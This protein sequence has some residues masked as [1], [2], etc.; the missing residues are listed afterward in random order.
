M[1]QFEMGDPMKKNVKSSDRKT[2]RAP[3]PGLKRPRHKADPEC[4][5]LTDQQI[6]LLPRI[7]ERLQG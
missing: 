7:G 2:K 1:M 6:A 5:N 4:A 3:K